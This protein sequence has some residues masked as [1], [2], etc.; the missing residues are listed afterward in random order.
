MQPTIASRFRFSY[1]LLLF[2]AACA[3]EESDLIRRTQVVMGSLVEITVREPDASK[4]NA[5]ID[6]AFDEMVRLE[7]LM[8]SHRADSEISRL[9]RESGKGYIRLSRETLDVVRRGVYWGNLSGGALDISIGPLAT[10]WRF[11]ED[12]KTVPAPEM[13]RHLVQFVDYQD[14][15]ID[16]VMVRL[17]RPDM[18]INLGAIAKGYAVDRAVEV[19]QSLGIQNAL[20]NAGGD[21]KIIGRRK[22]DLPWKIGL[23]HPRN[24]EDIIAAFDLPLGAVATSGDYQRYFIKDGVRYHH[25]LNPADGNPARAVISATVLAQTTMDADALATAAFVLGPEK[26]IALLDSLKEVEG[27]LVKE[28]GDVVFSRNFKSQPGFKLEGF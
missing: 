21:L 16:D 11:E 14:I 28:S 19:L 4:A 15:Q 5:A 10:L 25:I 13:L 9:N 2:G 1:L 22:P 12:L 3:Q 7:K 24:P 6:A 8:S 18:A 26:G 17:A 27:M 23:Q 20:V